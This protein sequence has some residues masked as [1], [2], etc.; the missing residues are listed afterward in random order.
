MGNKRDC[1]SVLTVCAAGIVFLYYAVYLILCLTGFDSPFMGIFALLVMAATSLP[2][3]FWERLRP[4]FGRAAR[5]IQIAF[6]LLLLLYIISVLAFWCYIGLDAAHTPESF[7]ADSGEDTLVLVFGCRTYGMNPSRSLALRLDAAL[8]L[9]GKMPEALCLVSGGQGSNETVTEAFAMKAHLVEN[10]I[11]EARIIMEEN[12]HSTSENVRFSKEIIEALGFTHKQIIGVSTAF[13][14]PRIE[15]LSRRYGLPMEVCA[16]PSPT[17]GHHY[18]SMVREYLSYIKMV[19][20]DQA[21]I[22]TRVT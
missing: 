3:Y 21:V 22:I 8:E 19:L 5:G 4:K 1:W 20:F 17:P 6:T 10:G 16:A 14:L 2:I 12:S 9:L 18:V 13:H 7:P 15:M 11:D